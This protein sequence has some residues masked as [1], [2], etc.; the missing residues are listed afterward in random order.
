MADEVVVAVGY[1]K[2]DDDDDVTFIGC[3]SVLLFTIGTVD[4]TE[5]CC[6]EYG[7][8]CGGCFV[9][10]VWDDG[11]VVFAPT[12]CMVDDDADVKS[13]PCCCSINPGSSSWIPPSWKLAGSKMME[14]PRGRCSGA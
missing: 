11:T 9:G 4:V 6:R 12:L 10:K 1:E 2:L 8:R 3:C 13:L 7:G 14:S 5:F